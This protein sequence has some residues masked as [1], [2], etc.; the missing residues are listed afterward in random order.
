MYVSTTIQTIPVSN[1]HTL[2]GFWPMLLIPNSKN[3]YC[4]AICA[5]EAI[6]SRSAAIVPQPPAN[7]PIRGPSARDAQVKLVPQSGSTLFISLLAQAEKNIGMNASTTIN[8]VCTPIT[9]TTNPS[10]AARLYA[11]AV[12]AIPIAVL[13]TRPSALAFSPLR[14]TSPSRDGV[15]NSVAKAPI[16]DGQPVPTRH[17]G[18]RVVPDDWRVPTDEQLGGAR[19]PARTDKPDRSRKC[20]FLSPAGIA[21]HLP[22]ARRI[23]SGTPMSGTSARLP[24]AKRTNRADGRGHGENFEQQAAAGGYCDPWSEQALRHDRGARWA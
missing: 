4:P 23:R 22:K 3:R 8:G 17:T 20:A 15:R 18:L 16:L 19:D 24:R 10:V 12:E 14:T 7:Q 2:V 13:V 1:T 11:G 9:A 5:C 6:A 21:A